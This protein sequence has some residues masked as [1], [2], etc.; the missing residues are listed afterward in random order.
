MDRTSSIT[1]KT[2]SEQSQAQN[3]RTTQRAAKE[4]RQQNFYTTLESFFCQVR[5]LPSMDAVLNQSGSFPKQTFIHIFKIKDVLYNAV[6]AKAKC[7]EY[8]VSRK[9][10]FAMMSNP[11][12]DI[13]TTQLPLALSN[14]LNV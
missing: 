9:R 6:I 2:S 10:Q 1:A 5:P 8:R 13:S 3:G 14:Y 12:S 7:E 11:L 4:E